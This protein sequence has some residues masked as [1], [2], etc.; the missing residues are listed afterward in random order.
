MFLPQFDG[1]LVVDAVPPDF[2]ARLERRVNE[3]LL[4]RGSHVRAD[5]HVQRVTPDEIR[6]RAGSLWTAI[7]V[8]L[9]EVTV[10]RESDTRLT[11]AVTFWRWTAYA[12]SLCGGIAIPLGAFYVWFHLRPDTPAIPLWGQA[13]FWGSVLFWGIIWPWI[14]TAFHKPFVRRCLERILLEE[15]ADESS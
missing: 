12:V 15:L 6:F 14:L 10:R 9:N 11:Y 7:N 2:T 5:Y 8:G 1:V 4:V 13:I 3:G